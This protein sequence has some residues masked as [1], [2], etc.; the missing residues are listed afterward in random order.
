MRA[1]LCLSVLLAHPFCSSSSQLAATLQ[2]AL[3]AR[4]VVVVEDGPISSRDGAG[5]G[6]EGGGPVPIV[7]GAG[8]CALASKT[9][10]V[11]VPPP[12]HGQGELY[13]EHDVAA[14]RLSRAQ[15]AVPPTGD[16]T[17]AVSA[18]GEGSG[19]SVELAM[20]LRCTGRGV[21]HAFYGGL[22]ASLYHHSASTGILSSN[23]EKDSCIDENKA[24]WLP[25]YILVACSLCCCLLN[26]LLG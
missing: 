10:A 5:F 23:G 8:G 16:G 11:F 14:M 17:A 22:L 4:L 25:L 12:N 20:T 21:M 3:D 26:W 18:G 19:A 15:S 2:Q 6:A 9:G 7:I 13:N 24:C 1:V